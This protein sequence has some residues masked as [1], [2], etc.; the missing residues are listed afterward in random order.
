VGHGCT[1]VFL[2]NSALKKVLQEKLNLLG[3]NHFLQFLWNRFSWWILS[4]R[5]VNIFDFYTEQID[6]SWPILREEKNVPP[7]W[8]IPNLLDLLMPWNS[9]TKCPLVSLTG[10]ELSHPEQCSF[11]TY[12]RLG[13]KSIILWLAPQI[14]GIRQWV[15]WIHSALELESG[16]EQEKAENKAY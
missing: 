14:P 4:L 15:T 12:L 9:T 2:K 6:F 13:F 7:I 16:K 1:H 10:A 8:P 3:F 11:D 5:Y